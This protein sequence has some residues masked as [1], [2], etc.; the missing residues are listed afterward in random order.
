RR[1]G[2]H[3][4]AAGAVT[5]VALSNPNLL[6]TIGVASYEV[7]VTA[8]LVA[9]IWAF[10]LHVERSSGATLVL[11]A[12][13]LTATALTRSLFHPVWILAVLTLAV[14]ARPVARR[15]VAVAV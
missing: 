11:L 2:V 12:A 15:A 9:S 7:P 4:V 5:V 1:W 14:L 6:S 3:P 8:L 10:Q 13:L